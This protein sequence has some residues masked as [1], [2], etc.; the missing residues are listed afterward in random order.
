MARLV[1][2]GKSLFPGARVR[3]KQ[4]ALWSP[5]FRGCPQYSHQGRRRVSLPA[6][7]APG[8]SVCV[9]DVRQG[10]ARARGSWGFG[11]APG[12]DAGLQSN[13]EVAQGSKYFAYL[14]S[15][16]ALFDLGDPG[17]RGAD[18]ARQFGLGQA[19]MTACCRNDL[20]DFLRHFRQTRARSPLPPHA[21]FGLMREH[22]MQN[23]PNQ[24]PSSE[25]RGCPF[26]PLQ[27]VLP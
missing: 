4:I 26:E 6:A 27:I 22:R 13:A 24:L 9:N 14:G 7:R 23:R 5:A 10:R 1:K 11:L 19:A 15:I 21:S 2:R 12:D 17:L 20:A 18:R 16:L 25:I 8:S 3:C